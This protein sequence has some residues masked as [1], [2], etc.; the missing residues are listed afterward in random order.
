MVSCDSKEILA[1]KFS[2]SGKWLLAGGL[3]PTVHLWDVANE[4]LEK[5]YSADNGKKCLYSDGGTV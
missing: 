5:Q 3:N 1:L 4:T 2:P